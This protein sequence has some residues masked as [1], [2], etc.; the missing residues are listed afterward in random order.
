MAKHPPAFRF[1]WQAGVVEHVPGSDD[2][3]LNFSTLLRNTREMSF[4]WESDTAESPKARRVGASLTHGRKIVMRKL[5][6]VC[7]AALADV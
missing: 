6:L 1:L 4:R 7:L 3:G 5:L 2:A